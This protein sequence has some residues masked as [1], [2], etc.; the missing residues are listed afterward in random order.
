[1]IGHFMVKLDSRGTCKQ[2]PMIGQNYSN[3]FLLW[4]RSLWPRGLQIT[5]YDWSELFQ[6]C[7]LIWQG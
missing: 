5:P 1:M 2:Y 3:F 6:I 7:A 4:L